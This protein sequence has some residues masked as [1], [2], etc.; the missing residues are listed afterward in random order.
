MSNVNEEVQQFM[1]AHGLQKIVAF[2]GGADESKS[3]VESI[4]YSAMARFRDKPVAILTGGTKWGVPNYASGI[5]K[6]CGLKTIGV[7]PERGKKYAL[8]ALDLRI[9]VPPVYGQSEYGDES[10]AFAKLADGVVMIGGSAGTAVEFWH[11][12]K[13][14]TRIQEYLAEGKTDEAIKLVVPMK[15]VRGFSETVMGLAIAKAVP[16]AFPTTD[17]YT[18]DCAGTYLVDRLVP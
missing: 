14:N 6:D 2:S 5:A 13:I 17:V 16:E 8:E 11:V 3:E 12:M 4:I 15:G 10:S 7:M 9:V 18:G 1:Q